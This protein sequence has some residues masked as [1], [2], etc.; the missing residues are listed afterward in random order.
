MDSKFKL[1][2]RYRATFITQFLADAMEALQLC[3]T[4]RASMCVI[5]AP[6][7]QPRASTRPRRLPL[8][9][10]VSPGRTAIWAARVMLLQA[11]STWGNRCGPYQRSE[12][13]RVGKEC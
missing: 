9:Q 2:E 10:Q 4:Q 13:R 6:T 1:K 3:L 5:K 8:Q 11:A 12:E 7:M